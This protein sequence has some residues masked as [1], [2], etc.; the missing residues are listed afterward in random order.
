MRIHALLHVPFEGLAHIGTWARQHGHAVSSTRF[1]QCDRLPAL[2][3]VDFL[4][5]MGGPMSIHDEDFFPWLIEEKQW[6]AQAIQA[7]KPV[8]GICLGAQLIASVLGAKVYRNRCKEIGWFPVRKMPL[9][10]ETP[11]TD[12]LPTALETF[13]WH[14]ETFDLPAGAVHLAASAACHNQAFLYDQRVMGLQF[15]LETTPES[16]SLLLTHCADDLQPG[17][18]Y[19]QTG[20]EIQEKAEH[21]SRINHVMENL[22]ARFAAAVIPAMRYH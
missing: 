21:F 11:L 17:G 18:E 15:H 20:R 10:S 13:H 7:G 3:Q 5:I 14:G 1:F 4:I 6:I 2:D 16:A 12:W 8:L 9:V 22:L 19:V